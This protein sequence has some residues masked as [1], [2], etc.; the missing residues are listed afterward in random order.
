[1]STLK[2]PASCAAVGSVENTVD[3]R[4]C[5]NPSKSPK[6]NAV[7]LTIGPPSTPPYWLRRSGGFWP[8]GGVKNVVAFMP[9]ALGTSPQY[10]VYLQKTDVQNQLRQP[11]LRTLSPKVPLP[12]T[13]SRREQQTIDATTESRVYKFSLSQLQNGDAVLVLSPLSA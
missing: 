6:K 4:F 2:I 7:F 3:L 5:R 1:M 8:S 11:L 13:I 12:A 9:P 10:V